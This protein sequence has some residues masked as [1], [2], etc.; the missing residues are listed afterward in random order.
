MFLKITNKM[1]CWYV[2][3]KGATHSPTLACHTPRPASSA[4]DGELSAVLATSSQNVGTE[5]VTVAAA[6]SMADN[7]R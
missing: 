4:L 1:L 2:H 7:A 6:W 3:I 5:N